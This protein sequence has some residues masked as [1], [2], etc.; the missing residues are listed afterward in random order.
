MLPLLETT[1]TLRQLATHWSN[2]LSARMEKHEVLNRLLAAFWAGHLRCA[3][4]GVGTGFDLRTR[5]LA[6]IGANGSHPGVLF[7]H[8]GEVAPPV[9]Q[10]VGDEI[11]ADLR[12][13]IQL[14]DAQDP[15]GQAIAYRALGGLALE[16][17]SHAAAP[18][19]CMLTVDRD[20]FQVFCVDQ[21]YE[22]PAFW[23]ARSRAAGTA[24]AESRAVRWFQEQAAKGGHPPR[25]AQ[26]LSELRRRFNI[27]ERAALRI[28]SGHAPDAWKTPGPKKPGRT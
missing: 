11:Q 14:P 10:T 25:K 21:G 19:L 22:L 16:D 20:D 18:V 15:A 12:I 24:A 7:L 2:E 23:F 3:L 6:T 17:F 26:M 4:A 13:R 28:W 5:V 8:K 1:L 9:V 27:A